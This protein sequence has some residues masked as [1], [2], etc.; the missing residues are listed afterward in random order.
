MVSVLLLG[1]AELS[2]HLIDFSESRCGTICYDALLDTDLR[3]FLSLQSSRRLLIQFRHLLKSRLVVRLGVVASGCFLLGHQSRLQRRLLIIAH[4][5][6]SILDSLVDHAKLLVLLSRFKGR[7]L[8]RLLVLCLKLGN[9][10][11][12][13]WGMRTRTVSHGRTLR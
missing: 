7:L 5:R 3:E 13:E 8:L 12:S 9:V 6:F 1:L 2:L 4:Q 11:F 10:C